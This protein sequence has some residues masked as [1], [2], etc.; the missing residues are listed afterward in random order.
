MAKQSVL[1][2]LSAGQA[3]RVAKAEEAK[4]EEAE[5]PEITATLYERIA[6]LEAELTALNDKA[7]QAE[8]LRNQ[9]A[10]TRMLTEERM[11]VLT[12]K[13]AEMETRISGLTDECERLETVL[14]TAHAETARL[15]GELTVER[16]AR[17]RT[18]TTLNETITL[19]ANRK[20]PAPVTK[21]GKPISYKLEVVQRDGNEQLREA[22]LVP[23]DMT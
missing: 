18:E 13:T 3:L 8:S 14:E 1:N 21:P 15:S 6:K 19:L 22:R 9:E 12:A 5:K 16:S 4:H 10:T 11:S 20:E 7:N 2:M 23:E 17:A